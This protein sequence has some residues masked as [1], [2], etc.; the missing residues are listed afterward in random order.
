MYSSPLEKAPKSQLAI[1][2]PSTGGHWKLP[3]RD[4]PLPKTRSHSEMVGVAQSR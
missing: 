3:K 4:A 2:Q 1:E